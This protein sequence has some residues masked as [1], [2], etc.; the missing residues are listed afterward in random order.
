MPGSPSG[1]ESAAQRQRHSWPRGDRR[2]VLDLLRDGVGAVG[3]GEVV[4][5]VAMPMREDV[6]KPLPRH[7][8]GHEVAVL[9]I[10]QSQCK[11]LRV[12]VERARAVAPDGPGELVKDED[13]GQAAPRVLRPVVESPVASLVV[14]SEKRVTIPSSAP[15]RIRQRQWWLWVS[16]SSSGLSGNQRCASGV[17]DC[18]LPLG[19]AAA[20]VPAW[21]MAPLLCRG[22]RTGWPRFEATKGQRRHPSRRTRTGLHVGNGHRS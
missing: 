9:Q 19:A 13:E 12:L 11:R 2:S 18:A 22:G 8:Q 6:E 10:L 20:F 7:L 17:A 21:D 1:T 5:P 14:R 16:G 15:P 4:W 3:S